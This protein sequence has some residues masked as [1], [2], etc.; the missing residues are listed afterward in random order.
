MKHRH[1]LMCVRTTQRL[2]TDVLSFVGCRSSTNFKLASLG[3]RG[4]QERAL[5]VSDDNIGT[6]GSCTRILMKTTLVVYST[7]TDWCTTAFFFKQYQVCCLQNYSTQQVQTAVHHQR[8]CIW[9][10][11]YMESNSVLVAD[12]NTT[13]A[14]SPTRRGARPKYVWSAESPTK[15]LCF[16]RSVF[17]L[18]RL[19]N[20][21]NHRRGYILITRA[22]PLP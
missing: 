6:Y 3:M 5:L 17:I 22:W 15:R 12:G 10:C 11:S 13:S 20:K 19:P 9:S 21:H 18:A 16:P 8:T 2:C 4:A 1:Q 7:S 14:V